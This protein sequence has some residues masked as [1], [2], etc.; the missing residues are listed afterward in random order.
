M[1]RQVDRTIRVTGIGEAYYDALTLEAWIKSSSLVNEARSLLC[2][3]L[4]RREEYRD[5]ILTSLA[6]KRGVQLDT[7]KKQ[8]LT[9]TAQELAP[10]EWV[11]GEVTPKT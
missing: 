5:R 1:A 9:G 11:D 4:M 6:T 3:T 2:S 8:I 10:G 7:L